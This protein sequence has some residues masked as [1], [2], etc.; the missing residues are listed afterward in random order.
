MAR[1]VCEGCGENYNICNIDR[2]GYLMEP[3]NP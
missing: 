1:R 2:D 3:L